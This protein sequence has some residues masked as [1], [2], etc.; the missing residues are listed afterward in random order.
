MNN[1]DRS[2][3]SG[4]AF[5]FGIIGLIFGIYAI[6]QTRNTDSSGGAAAAAAA[7]EVVDISLS[8][9]AITPPMPSVPAGDVT[10]RVT[11]NGTI[12]HNVTFGDRGIS[13]RDLQ[14]GESQ[15]LTLKNLEA[16]EV[17]FI[18]TIPGHSASGMTGMLMV[19]GNS[20]SS[21]DSSA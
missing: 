4:G 14:P 15:T 20:A 3:L 12:A 16:G 9:F 21:D 18:C 8:E 1:D 11:N 2:V 5:I 7:P 13:T 10:I 19:G 6:V 17:D